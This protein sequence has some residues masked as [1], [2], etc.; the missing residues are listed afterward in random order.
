MAGTKHE[1][2][3]TVITSECVVCS[4]GPGKPPN[5]VLHEGLQL[6]RHGIGVLS[7]GKPD[8]RVRLVEHCKNVHMESISQQLLTRRTRPTYRKQ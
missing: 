3:S 8:L 2:K 6:I 4:T 1:K 7:R 5:K